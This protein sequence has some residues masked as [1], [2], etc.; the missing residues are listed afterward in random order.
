[1][2]LW[3][4]ERGSKL[5]S[6]T[7]AS[8]A[9]AASE[10][11]IAPRLASMRAAR[12]LVYARS[13]GPIRGVCPPIYDREERVERVET[14]LGTAD[15]GDAD[16]AGDRANDDIW[17]GTGD[18]VVVDVNV[19]I[20][21][22]RD[23]LEGR[24]AADSAP[25]RSEVLGRWPQWMHA[26][27]GCS[28]PHWGP[29]GSGRTGMSPTPVDARRGLA[30][31]VVWTWLSRSCLFGADGGATCTPTSGL[32]RRRTGGGAS[33]CTS[34]SLRDLVTRFAGLLFGSDGDEDGGTLATDGE[35]QPSFT[36]FGVEA[37]RRGVGVALGELMTSV[38]VAGGGVALD[39]VFGLAF[40]FADEI[41]LEGSDHP[42]RLRV[43]ALGLATTCMSSTS[44]S[45]TT[46][47]ISGVFGAVA[48]S[49]TDV[50]TTELRS[51]LG[52]PPS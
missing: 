14:E 16:G 32:L 36:L 5:T 18:A 21:G 26:Y 4:G 20:D 35:E 22:A 11:L 37:V 12:D 29:P 31:G 24:A 27:S 25:R 33:V 46:L 7:T 51:S 42:T 38:G 48:Y 3:I 30:V 41:A 13:L 52:S 10:K 23:D 6:C 50:D 49:D 2:P 15:A 39:H 19:D 43:L 28:H 9:C 40:A 17:D 1:M 47:S 45:R 44:S 8:A 34:A